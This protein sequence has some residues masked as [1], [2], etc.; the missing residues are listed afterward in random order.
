ME[1]D[2]RNNVDVL[3]NPDVFRNNHP[4]PE[5]VLILEQVSPDYSGTKPCSTIS[6][7]DNNQGQKARN[8]V[9]AAQCH[10]IG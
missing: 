7:F 6:L 3:G 9:F 2:R 8:I 10:F 1:R 4:D 5:S